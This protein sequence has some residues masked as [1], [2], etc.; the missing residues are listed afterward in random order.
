MIG[1]HSP[2]VTMEDGC[3]QSCGDHGGRVFKPCCD[4]KMGVDTFMVTMKGGYSELCGDLGR[5]VWALLS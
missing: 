2:V 3:S 1:V 5:W 4:W